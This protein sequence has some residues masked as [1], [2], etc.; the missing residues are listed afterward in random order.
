MTLMLEAGAARPRPA[1]RVLLSMRSGAAAAGSSGC[2]LRVKAAARTLGSP[3]Q[4]SRLPGLGS[5]GAANGPERQVT[6]RTR[7]AVAPP[8]SHPY[9]ATSRG[10][11][12]V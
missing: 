2:S 12:G 1:R 6:G 8:R 10:C 5:I 11:S 7:I 4:W 9:P 3:R